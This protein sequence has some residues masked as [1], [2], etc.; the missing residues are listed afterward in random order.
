MAINFINFWSKITFLLRNILITSVIPIYFLLLT[1]ELSIIFYPQEDE[2]PWT[3]DTLFADVSSN[4]NAAMS[5]DAI[6]VN[7]A[8]KIGDNI[9]K[10]V[11]YSL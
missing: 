6:S 4:L 7:G 9:E 2:T 5:Q 1:I 11:W 8:D 10:I 3:W